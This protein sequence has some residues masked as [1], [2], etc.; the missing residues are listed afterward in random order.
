MVRIR[1]ALLFFIRNILGVALVLISIYLCSRNYTPNTFLTGWDTL[2]PEF[3]YRIYWSRILG[4]VWQEHQGL[5]A[6]ASQ[7]HASEIPRV[8]ILMFF[9]L[10]LKM[11]QIR[12]AYAFLMLVLGPLGVYVFFNK[13][14]SR[15]AKFSSV[16]RLGAF[17]AGLLYLLNLGTLQQFYVPLEMFLTHYGFLGWVMLSL[18]GYLTTG[19]K[20]W[21]VYFA[22][23]TLLIAP[24]AHTPTLFY[25]YLMSLGI[26]LFPYCLLGIFKGKSLFFVDVKRSFVLI[27]CT[28]LINSFW[29]L[30]HVYFAVQH[31]SEVHLSKIHQL[32]SEEAFL[33][34]KMFGNIK[35]IALVKNF[36]FNWGEYKGYN[37][38]GDLMDRWQAHLK[39]PYVLGIGYAL[40]IISC[41]GI[42]FGIFKKEKVIIGLSGMFL[43]SIFFL[44]TTNPPLGFIFEWFQNHIPLFKE[45]FRLPFTKFS[46]LFVFAY[47]VFFGYALATCADVISRVFRSGIF[48][49]FVSVLVSI[50]VVAT[51]FWYMY[52]AFNGYFISPSMRMNIP[53]R[54]FKMFDYFNNQDE[55]GRVANLPIH[56]F[57]GWVYHDWFEPSRTGYQG[58]G[59]LWFGIKQPLMDREFDRWNIINEQYYREMSRAVYSEKVDLLESVLEKYKIRWLLFDSSVMAPAADEKLLFRENIKNLF[60]S[61]SKISLDKDFGDGLQVYK[62]SP[63]KGFADL[64]QVSNFVDSTSVPFK[65]YDDPVMNSNSNY[66][67]T[68]DKTNPFVGVTEYDESLKPGV[69]TSDENNLYINLSKGSVE[70]RV[71]RLDVY[72]KF[73]SLK[74][75]LTVELHKGSQIVFS[76]DVLLENVNVVKYSKLGLLFND[77]FVEVSTTLLATSEISQRVGAVLLDGFAGDPNIS[78]LL[79]NPIE[80][81]P[82]NLLK[83]LSSCE[84]S[85]ESA[86]YSAVANGTSLD[87]FAK[88]GTA[89]VTSSINSLL[90]EATP[91]SFFSVDASTTS[92]GAKSEVCIVNLKTDLCVNSPF[93]ETGYFVNGSLADPGAQYLLRVLVDA[94]LSNVEVGTRI[95]KLSIVPFDLVLKETIQLSSVP[96]DGNTDILMI[97][98]P[99]NSIRHAVSSVSSP[100]VCNSGERNFSD[101]SIEGVLNQ[102]IRYTSNT[103]SLC[104]TYE[105]PSFLH[106]TGFIMEVKARNVEGLPLRIC[107]TNEYSKRCNAY[108]SMGYSKD[109]ETK[110]FLIPPYDNYPGYTVNISNL[111]FGQTPGVNDLEYVALTPIPYNYL[112]NYGSTPVSEPGKRLIVLNQA[113]EPGW[114]ALCGI[115]SC[116]MEHKMFNGWAN[117]WVI[118]SSSVPVDIRPVFWPQ[119]LEV[120]GLVLSFG[121]FFFLVLRAII[122]PAH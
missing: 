21:L 104:D 57:W 46:I 41:L 102:Y 109:F 117:S 35:D 24:Q 99:L 13:A 53:D 58:A 32:F 122:D 66:A 36:L 22:A 105:Y 31:G 64:E 59:F 5:G 25:A 118:E 86:S 112:R 93:S 92:L 52:P 49:L 7:A 106:N 100:R 94:K 50:A 30:P 65:E 121:T 83:T 85:N 38:Y 51:L 89:C 44:L 4:G 97:P 19:S 78:V 63:E 71:S 16:T 23:F 110:Y 79:G 9:S 98:R 82:S 95:E 55:Y 56:T 61:S 77:E 73:D 111:V 43:L 15:L 48:A 14:F 1:L 120:L 39:E 108:V 40:F 101:S 12:Y 34:N 26:F 18:Y 60:I 28:M 37:V 29:F 20:K 113:Y 67:V 90:G 33:Q 47:A 62:Y 84:A 74:G 8:V 81:V 87:L 76:K 107:L 68:G 72:S 70:N 6:V 17:S 116:S 2:H 3:N 91:A 75:L 80:V 54:Y 42:V 10:F 119:L 114:G 88:K 27:F 45:V 115:V 103:E 11:N 96:D 69:V